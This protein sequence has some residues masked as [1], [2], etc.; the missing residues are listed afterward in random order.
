MKTINVTKFLF[1]F[2]LLV[3]FSVWGQNV[4]MTNGGNGSACAGTFLDP[5]GTGN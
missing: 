5:G 4:I 2:L 1:T 3:N